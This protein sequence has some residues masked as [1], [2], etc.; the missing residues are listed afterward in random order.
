[1]L[2]RVRAGQTFFINQIDLR[3]SVTAT[4]D[5]G[6][7]GL[8]HN[9]AFAGLGWGGVR[10]AEQEFEILP[11]PEGFK[12]RRFYRDAAWMNVPSTFTVEQVDADG[13]TV[14]QPL[15]LNAGANN[16]RREDD[17]FFVRRFRAI[18]WAYDCAGVDNCE[19]ANNFMEEALVELRHAR[20]PCK[21]KQLVLD[22]RTTSLRLR[23]SLSR[24]L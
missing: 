21:E 3:G 2:L 17:D 16:K 14:G 20:T 5:E 24:E 19:G 15:H 23:W 18:Q 22:A 11:G 4:T 8:R 6:V 1:M 9:G 10:L 12:R 13:N 7:D